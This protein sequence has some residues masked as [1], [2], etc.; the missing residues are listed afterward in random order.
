MRQLVIDTATEALSVALFEEGRLIASHHEIAGRGHAEK[1]LPII[2]ALDGGGRA[3][4]I[5]VNNGPG[6]FTGVR[7]GLAAARALS[8]AWGI[9]LRAYSSLS[10]VAAI[11]RAN[12]DADI[13]ADR[14]AV[15]AANTGTHGATLI[16][17]MNGGHGELF[18]QIFDSTTLIPVTQP[19]ST[20]TAQLAEEIKADIYYGTGAGA[21]VAAQ[22]ETGKA[23][24]IHPDARAFP[25]IPVHLLHADAVPLYGRGADAI[26]LSQRKK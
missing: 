12:M 1:L 18:W 5:I 15:S 6:S 26:P 7:V 2:A 10:L 21:L 23:V 17:T 3:D 24:V 13:G 22:G 25:L 11:A 4:E 20:P 14:G 9:R 16:I 19:A 8:Y